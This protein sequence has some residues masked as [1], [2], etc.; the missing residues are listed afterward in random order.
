MKYLDLMMYYLD[1]MMY[2]LDL[3]M[4]YYLFHLQFL[5]EIK[6]VADDVHCF[7]FVTIEI[8]FK[9]LTIYLLK[10][11]SDAI[12]NK[13]ITFNNPLNSNK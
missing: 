9:E 3:M 6:N 4:Y 1:L 2:Y 8:E 5:F 11:V 7:I 13:L 12:D 10:T